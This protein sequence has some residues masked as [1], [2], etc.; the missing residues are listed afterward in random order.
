MIFPFALHIKYKIHKVLIIVSL[1]S[2]FKQFSFLITQKMLMQY[3]IPEPMPCQI[4]FYHNTSKSRLKNNFKN[5]ET[6][7]LLLINSRVLIL[8]LP[9]CICIYTLLY[10][11]IDTVFIIFYTLKGFTYFSLIPPSLIHM[12]FPHLSSYQCIWTE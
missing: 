12:S 7:K 9:A 6:K 1:K 2:V 11:L 3:C 10:I 4:V 5:K 8:F